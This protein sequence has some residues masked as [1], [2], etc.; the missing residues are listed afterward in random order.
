VELAAGVR[1]LP[2]DGGVWVFRG[3]EP[4]WDVFGPIKIGSNVFIGYG[5]I[6]LPGTVIEDNCVIGAGSV[7]RGVVPQNSVAAGVPARR[8]RSLEEYKCKLEKIALPTK[9][10]NREEKRAYLS[11]HFEL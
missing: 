10:M 11:R 9:K 7:V 4:D 8:I 5:A 6:I 1:F 2:H 3:E